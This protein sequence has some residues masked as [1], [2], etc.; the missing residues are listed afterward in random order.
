MNPDAGFSAV[1]GPNNEYVIQG[2]WT[3][4]TVHT[5]NWAEGKSTLIDTIDVGTDS[6]IAG[7]SR[8]NSDRSFNCVARTKA[9]FRF[10]TKHGQ[11][12]GREFYSIPA[13]ND[14]ARPSWSPATNYMFV[15]TMRFNTPSLKKL[16]RVHSDR[17]TDVAT[18]NTGANSA[19]YGV[20][21]DT[22]WLVVSLDGLT[23]RRVYDYTNGHQG[24]TDAPLKTHSK[25]HGGDDLGFVTPEDHGKDYYVVCRHFTKEIYTTKRD[26]AHWLFQ[27]LDALQNKA[28]PPTWIEDTDLVVVPT[29]GSKF[30]IVDVFDLRKPSPVYI[31]YQGFG[32]SV[33]YGFMWPDRR[34]FLMAHSD[35]SLATYKGAPHIPCSDLCDTCDEV[36]RNKCLSCGANSVRQ[37]MHVGVILGFIRRSFP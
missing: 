21:F 26:G 8:I 7:Y 24:G 15:S 18:F 10:N 17:V 16:Y 6:N 25:V 35:S 22:P 9:V 33:V 2:R 30:A 11:P 32:T 13:G 29:I 12:H 14:Y 36:Y 37:E 5:I 3:V 31:L 28:D 27:D 20:L 34:V 1:G 23:V 19:S 4:F